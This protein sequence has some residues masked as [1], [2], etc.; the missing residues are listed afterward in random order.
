MCLIAPEFQ[1]RPFVK[2]LGDDDAKQ[3]EKHCWYVMWSA[4]YDYERLQY[5]R[6]YIGIYRT[7]RTRPDIT[8]NLVFLTYSYQ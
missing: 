8:R 1:I 4:Q 6:V 2:M 5:T 7:P 3:I